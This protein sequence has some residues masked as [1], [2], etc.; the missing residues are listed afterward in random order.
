MSPS[1]FPSEKTL[2]NLVEEAPS[3]LPLSGS[4]RLTVIGREVLLGSGYADLLALEEDGRPVVIEVKL[5][6][7]SEAR[8]AVIAQ[9]LSYA[10]ALY[11]MTVADLEQRCA[12]YLVG[13][14]HHDIAAAVA[15]EDQTGAFDAERFQT[16][17]AF[18]LASGEFRVVV[19]LDDAPSDLVTIARYLDDVG[20][21]LLIDVLTVHQFTVGSDESGE[22]ILV[23]ERVDLDRPPVTPPHR[24]VPSASEGQLLPGVDPFIAA[25]AETPEQEHARLHRLVE[26]ARQLQADGLVTL[27]T[28]R[29]KS[30]VTLLPRLR[31]EGVGLVTIWTGGS[32]FG[33]WRSV[34]ERRAP[35]SLAVVEVLIAPKSLGQGT[36]AEVTD[37]L[38]AALRAAYVEATGGK[39]SATANTG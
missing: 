6:A 9:V 3:V 8:R 17:L 11:A 22:M 15:S 10:A 27:D 34:F 35:E 2:H 32:N 13:K 36:S 16:N 24:T 20:D 12:A 30:Q 25:I 5:A 7:N 31:D 39:R 1:G 38:L 37:E 33:M 4:P 18:Y 29:G 23:P 26:W 19:V 28:Y 14:G 21:R